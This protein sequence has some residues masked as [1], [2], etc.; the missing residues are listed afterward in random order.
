MCCQRAT[1]CVL[2]CAPSNFLD[3]CAAMLNFLDFY[4]LKMKFLF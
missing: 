1:W 4:E 2:L 3:F